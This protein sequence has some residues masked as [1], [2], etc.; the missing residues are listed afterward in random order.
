MSKPVVS[1][2]DAISAYRTKL[3]AA[4]DELYAA[5]GDGST[6]VTASEFI[7][8]LLDDEDA[9]TARATLGAISTAVQSAQTVTIST[10][11]AA[12]TVPAAGIA[13]V[14]LAA[15]SGTADDLTSFSGLSNGCFVVV[16]ADAGDTI[17]VKTSGNISTG[18]LG[19]A[20]LVGDDKHFLLFVYDGTTANLV[21]A[22]PNLP[23]FV[24]EVYAYSGNQTLT[25][26]QCYGSTIY[27]TGAATITLP[28]VADGMSVRV[29]TI[30]AVAVSVDPDAADLIR[31]EGAALDDGDKITNASTSGDEAI[32]TYY[33]ADGWYASTNGWT[34]GGA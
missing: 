12:V 14:I 31:L 13:N 34:D 15:E 5:I 32:L 3:N 24:Q 23:K 28:P 10:G 29:V 8:T 1:T 2:A 11:A 30:G 19:D 17:T 6:L 26:S 4:L 21:A 25:A 20:V 22:S 33:S 18:G 9:A 7:K 27:V 16:R